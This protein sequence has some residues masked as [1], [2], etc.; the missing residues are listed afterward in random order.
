MAISRKANLQRD[1][2]S[3]ESFYSGR[4]SQNLYWQSNLFNEISLKYDLKRM[5]DYWD[6]HD[7]DFDLFL[8][9]FKDLTAKHRLRKF[10]T[11]KEL[12]T[13]REWIV[14]ILDLLGWKSDC[15]RD[16][17]S[18]TYTDNKGQ[19]STY[20]PDL[21]FVDH[22]DEKDLIIGVKTGNLHDAKRLVK[23][24]VEA[25]AWR[26]LERLRQNNC[27]NQNKAP[28]EPKDDSS[29]SFAPEDQ[30]I[31]YQNIL[32][33]DFGILT[34]GAQ[35]KLLHRFESDDIRKKSFTFNLEA[36]RQEFL[37]EK[38]D[39]VLEGVVDELK[40][41][42]YLFRKE[43]F[44]SDSPLCHR[45]LKSN[46]DYVTA[47]IEDMKENFVNAMSIACNGFAKAYKKG[48]LNNTKLELIRNTAESHLFN[49]MFIK[50]CEANGVLQLKIQDYLPASIT[51]VINSIEW[52][53]Y[54]PELGNDS[55]ANT[56]SLKRVFKQSFDYTPHGTELF[57]R[58]RN[59]YS[60]IE[61]GTFGFM[62]PG[63]GETVFTKEEKVFSKKYK[64]T[65]DTMVRLMFNL[66]FVKI[67]NKYQ[68]IPYNYFSPRQLGSIYESFL[69][70]QLLYAEDDLIYKDKK[71]NKANLNSKHLQDTKLPFVRK[72][73]LYFNR[74]LK[75]RKNTGSYYTPDFIVRYLVDETISECLK[76]KSSS[77]ILKIR[78]CDPAMG[79]S[80]FL[81]A[82][83][84]YLT[85]A[86]RQKLLAEINDDL[87]ESF[88]ES[89]RKVLS[90]CVYGVDINPRAVK[91]S[92]MALWLVTAHAGSKLE[93]LSDQL[94]CA[95]SLSDAMKWDQVVPTRDTT[96]IG[97]FD[98]IIGNPPYIGEKG[99]KDLFDPLK[100]QRIGKYYQGKMDYFYFFV[101]LGIDLLKEC[102]RL[103][104]ITTNYFL[105]SAGGRKL[106]K[107]IYERT[108]LL[109]LIN[110]GEWR[111]FKDAQ[112]QH[113]SICVLEKDTAT[114][115]NYST[116]VALFKGIGDL[117]N[118]EA[119][120]WEQLKES[121][122]VDFKKIFD[123]NEYYIHTSS[124]SNVDNNI[125]VIISKMLRQSS[126]IGRIFNVNQ[127]IVSGADK[128]SDSHLSKYPTIKGK[129]GD[130]IFVLGQQE[131]KNMALNAD[132]RKMLKPFFKNS[133]VDKFQTINTSDQIIIYADRETKAIPEQLTRHL[134]QFKP[135]LINRREVKND[136]IKWFQLQWPRQREIFESPK[137]VVPQRSRT[138]TFGYNEIPWY[139]SADV[140]FITSNENSKYPLKSLLGILNSKLMYFWLYHKG[141]R[142][143]DA[144]ELYQK[145]LSEIPI[146]DTPNWDLAKKI[147][148]AS[149]QILKNGRNQ[150]IE[151]EI[152]QHVYTLYGVNKD[153]VKV[154]ESFYAE[155]HAEN[156]VKIKQAS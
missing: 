42:Y 77:E 20:R 116:K 147:E 97:I 13:I 5:V 18:F 114:E 120:F 16:N 34:D 113:N 100:S 98:A 145:P 46:K 74:D 50:S 60:I 33:K 75:D 112:G 83:V 21:L 35:W 134:S 133:E 88:T 92:K 30:L 58:L 149:N 55:D 11:W 54:K 107:D 65:N 148:N 53:N 9:G 66:G 151:A 85:K 136:V 101:H 94:I 150:Q 108:K 39:D 115:K 61:K 24:I 141:K 70:Y 144:L 110:L 123:E 3:Q 71:W 67:D 48:A 152:D 51:E 121:N 140:Y 129:K 128:L 37:R 96:T 82:A 19:K 119:V 130:G 40:Y 146:P 138:N 47:I 49:I 90:K 93:P 78:V 27:S 14:P 111:L 126:P 68:Q 72:S 143:G 106:R 127:G 104:Y 142:K 7:D 45:L 118:N 38:S 86:Y 91:L 22:P 1:T 17:A 137:I 139:A 154:I 32:Q 89:A 12:D 103:G 31:N 76:G 81:N 43:A 44:Y 25:K 26:N 4:L 135:I 109:N 132:E 8:Q 124:S 79:S 156:E 57:D 64:L 56:L 122:S 102:G 125:D 2:Q 6:H 62:I 52:P 73:S 84:E 131:L 10:D 80:H 105:T 99:H 41:F 117:N 23:M 36:I 69:E 95:D 153:E 28:S 15:Y 155:K 29:K 87:D 63:F 59:L